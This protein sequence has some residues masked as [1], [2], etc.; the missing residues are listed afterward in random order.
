M[1]HTICGNDWLRSFNSAQE[2]FKNS[3]ED[4]NNGEKHNRPEGSNPAELRKKL[5][6]I[7]VANRNFTDRKFAKFGQF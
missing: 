5:R 6:K 2:R 7:I 4:L 3:L 1:R